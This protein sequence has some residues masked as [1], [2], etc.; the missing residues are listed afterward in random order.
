MAE[1]VESWIDAVGAAERRG[2]PLAAFDLAERGLDDYPQDVWLRHRAVLALCRAGSTLEAKRRFEEYGL[3]AVDSEDV[4]ALGARIAKDMALATFG[5]DRSTAAARA[6][7]L[8]R[9]IHDRTGG[10]YPGVNAATMML[11]AGCTR[12]ARRMAEQVLTLVR[13]EEAESYY[14]AATEA[15]SLLVL[16]RTDEARRA[17][18][19]AAALNA[20]DHAAQATTRRQL[21]LICEISGIDD[22]LLSEIAGPSVVHYCGHRIH[23]GDHARFPASAETTV[24]ARIAEVLDR[25][26][27]GFAYGSLASGADIMWAEALTRA[28]R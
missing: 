16:G 22:G 18:A 7:D 5:P 11:V 8:Y 25:D 13:H 15:E 1:P 4:Q 21:R 2:E 10:Y 6:A 20:G 28:G 3:A 26:A 9:E 19:R 23:D 17:L 24:A 12:A 27:P 14:A